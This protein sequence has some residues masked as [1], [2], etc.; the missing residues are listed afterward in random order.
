MPFLISGETRRYRSL[1]TTPSGD[2]WTWKQRAR[3]PRFPALL[4]LVVGGSALGAAVFGFDVLAVVLTLAVGVGVGLTA[5][6]PWK[7]PRHGP[8]FGAAVLGGGAAVTLLAAWLI[9]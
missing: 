2:A 9:W 3:D 6:P 1:M 5:L 7:D 8:L 4:C